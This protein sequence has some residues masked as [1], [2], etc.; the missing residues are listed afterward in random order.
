MRHKRNTTVE[1][2]KAMTA[3]TPATLP[4]MMPM[5]DLEEAPRGVA[6]ELDK[7]GHNA[8][9]LLQRIGLPVT[10]TFKFGLLIKLAGT[11]PVKLLPS[12]NLHDNDVENGF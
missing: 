11:E 5:R 8:G 4:R 6:T 10:V 2:L 1:M 12:K 7:T 3:S 9:L